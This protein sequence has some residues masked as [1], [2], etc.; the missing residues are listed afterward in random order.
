MQDR[1]RRLAASLAIASLVL[2]LASPSL[3]EG[4]LA[5][6]GD[7]V[8]SVPMIFDVVV[9]RPIGLTSTIIGSLF[10]LFPVMPIMAI[11]RPSDIGKPLGPLVGA[12]ARFTFKDPIGQHPRNF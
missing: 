1:F 3:A 11:T 5:E 8:S 10:Y 6:V 9:M 7:E 4:R 12:P 2:S